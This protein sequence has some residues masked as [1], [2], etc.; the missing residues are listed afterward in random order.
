MIRVYFWLGYPVYNVKMYLN[1]IDYRDL[2]T[3]FMKYNIKS[4][5]V[6]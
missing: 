1:L 2:R 5:I 4:K 3:G 6:H